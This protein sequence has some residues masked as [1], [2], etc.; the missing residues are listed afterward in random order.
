MHVHA[1]HKPRFETFLPLLVANGVT[2][3]RDMATHTPLEEVSR[4]KSEIE[5]G[6]RIGPRILAAGRILDGSDPVNPNVSI[7]IR[8]EEE[9]RLAV[10]QLREQGADFIKV[11]SRLSRNVYYAIADEAREQGLPF[12]G[13][14]P[15]SITGCEASVA[16]QKSLEHLLVW[17][18]LE[19]CSPAEADQRASRAESPNPV[20]GIVRQID[21]IQQ[22]DE[23]RARALA[24]VLEANETWLTPTLTAREAATYFDER[25]AGTDDR[26][27]YISPAMRESWN[28][29]PV[30]TRFTPDQSET[31]RAGF[32]KTLQFV[33][34]MHRAGARLLAGTDTGVPY[35]FPGFD[36]HRELQLFVGAGLSPLEALQT[37]TINPARYL[38][39]EAELGTI[40]RGKLADLLLLDAD[41]L[42]DITNTTRINAVIANGRL[43]DRTMLDSILADAEAAAQRE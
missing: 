15:T 22:Y 26:I 2:G 28:Q 43:L 14:V 39:R 25:L 20:L 10:R 5:G 16:G 27:R 3:I 17:T 31:L 37:A 29:H 6:T 35:V 41:P 11:Y 33:G 30:F 18:W 8:D 4:W 34:R 12:A 38:G 32:P 23:T 21:A 19:G 42:T 36:L 24:S 40:A 13:H 7:P 9:G 1:L